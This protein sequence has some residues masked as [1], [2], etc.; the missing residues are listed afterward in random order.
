MPLW[1]LLIRLYRVNED[2]SY[3]FRDTFFAGVF[4]GAAF[5]AGAFAVF[6]PVA[7]LTVPAA[8]S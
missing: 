7:F 6:F 2:G 1:I 5:F 4:F 8:F 3:F